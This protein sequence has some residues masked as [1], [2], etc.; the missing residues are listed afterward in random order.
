[1]LQLGIRYIANL[2]LQIRVVTICTT[3]ITVL[4]L[5]LLHTLCIDVICMDFIQYINSLHMQL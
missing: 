2:D 3:R 1:V 5:C 4:I